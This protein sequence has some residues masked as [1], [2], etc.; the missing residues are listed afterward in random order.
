MGG[1][2]RLQMPR[3]VSLHSSSELDQL[4]N[5]FLAGKQCLNEA[6]PHRLTQHRKTTGDNRECVVI[7]WSVAGHGPKQNAGLT[8]YQ[9]YYY[10]LI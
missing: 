7:E 2:Q 8:N 6:Q 9:A 3:D 4:G 5:V 10:L 1:G